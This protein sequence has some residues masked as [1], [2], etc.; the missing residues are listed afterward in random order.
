[1]LKPTLSSL[2]IAITSL[3]VAGSALADYPTRN[4]QGTIQWG[5]GGATDNVIRSLTPHVEE[6][7][8]TT[9]VLTNRAGGTGVI[10]MNHVMNQRPDGYNLLFGAENPQLYPLMGLAD[11]TYDDMHTVNIIGQGLV[12][13][14]THPDSPFEDFG[15]LLEYAKENPGE[16]R[17][18][19]TGAGGLPS[20]VLAMIN[21]VDELDIRDVTFGGDGPGVT[22]LLGEHIDFMPLSLSAVAEQIRGGRLKGLAVLSDQELEDLPGVPPITEALPDIDAF[23]PWG[24]FWGVFVHQDTPDDVKAVLEDA[25]YN[26]VASD[27]FQQF[28]DDFGGAPLNLSGD[29]AQEYLDNWQSVTAWSMYDAEA[30]T[31]EVS[32]E[33]LGI[34]RP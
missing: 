12:V 4:I 32:P 27:E 30:E 18:G 11:F 24:P 20:T 3:S 22:A 6:E 17:M 8:G 28:L 33:E 34:P 2:A 5:A 19:G 21:A 10:G 9:I 23:L 25:Y 13:I 14:A 26:A 16:L 1:M 29:E 15:E 7:L 31:I